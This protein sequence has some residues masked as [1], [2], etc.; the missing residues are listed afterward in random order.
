M[1]LVWLTFGVVV[2]A[3]V[4]QPGNGALGLVAGIVAGVSVLLPVGLVLGLTG[5][6]ATE[7][8]IGGAAGQLSGFAASALGGW[9]NPTLMATAGLIYGALAGATF[10]GVCYRLPRFLLARLPL[11]NF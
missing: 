11:R 4:A 5:G 8:L 1:A 6:R 3:G 7:T 9:G 2:G 10:V